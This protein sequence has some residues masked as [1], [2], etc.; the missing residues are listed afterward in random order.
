MNSTQI[1][2]LNLEEVRR[3]STKV[4]RGIPQHHIDWRPDVEAMTCIEMIRHVLEGE[5]LYMSMLKSGGSVPSDETPWT[6]RPYTDIEG[7]IEF[8]SRYRQE[9]LLL[10]G[11][12]TPENLTTIK[13]DRS[14]KGYVRSASDFIL[15]MAYHESVHTGQLLG[16]L[17]LMNVPRPKIW[18]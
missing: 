5:Y 10:V 8:A 15:R 6:S 16:Y 12:Y 3:R 4:W 13:V 14:D 9:L 11:S 7:E 1:L 18:D 2:I 17:R